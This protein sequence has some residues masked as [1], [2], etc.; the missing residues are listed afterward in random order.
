[1]KTITRIAVLIALTPFALAADA[2]PKIEGVTGRYIE[3]RTAS[4]F[5]GACHY[6]AEYTTAGREAVLAWQFDGG[7]VDGVSVAGVTFVA[8]VV[9]DVN[10]A[11]EGGKHRSVVYLPKGLAAERRGAVLAWARATHG[12]MLGEVLAVREAAVSFEMEKDAFDL[13]AGVDLRLTGELMSDRSCC[14]M[15]SKV[16]YRPFDENV[17]K[18]IV[19]GVDSFKCKSAELARTWETREANCVFYGRFG[20][21]V[22]TS[23]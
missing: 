17:A 16:W 6:G 21:D 11:A 18:P 7:T 4:V 13:Q 5:A 15:P 22:P 3:A 14:S 10:L 9:A 19:G 12:E 20:G 8:A 2:A 23:S 1:M